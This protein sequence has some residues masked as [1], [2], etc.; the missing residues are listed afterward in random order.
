MLSSPMGPSLE[1]IVGQPLETYMLRQEQR[2]CNASLRFAIAGTIGEEFLMDG[3][4]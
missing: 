3:Q 4:V 1:P 2:G